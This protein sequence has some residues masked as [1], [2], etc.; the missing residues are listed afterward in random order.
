MHKV[1]LRLHL[2]SFDS[3]GFSVGS[4]NSENQSGYNF[5]AWC[6]NA[7]GSSVT[8]TDYLFDGEI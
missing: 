5:V 7:G 2:T 8:N 3:N 1:L 4:S 6:F